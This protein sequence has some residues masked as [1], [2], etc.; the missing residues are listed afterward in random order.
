MPRVE[1]STVYHKHIYL[2]KTDETPG[3]KKDFSEFSRKCTALWQEEAKT[4]R[5]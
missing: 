5:I 2:K 1:E 4:D 3:Q